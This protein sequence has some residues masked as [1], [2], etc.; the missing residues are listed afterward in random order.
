MKSRRAAQYAQD[1]RHK[2][3]E[4]SESSDDSSNDDDIGVPL[5]KPSRKHNRFGKIFL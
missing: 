2:V 3:E 5:Y 4:S 1:Q